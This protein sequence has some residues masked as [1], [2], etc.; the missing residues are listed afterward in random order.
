MSICDLTRRTLER[1]QMSE[2]K[3]L[4]E[5]RSVSKRYGKTQ[6]LDGISV[7][8]MRGRVY[9]LVGE[10]G[11]GKSTLVKI[12]C[13]A[14]T[15]D[16]GELL[17]AGEISELSSPQI[18]R[19]LGIS[20]V[21]QELS[22][23]PDL[24]LA[25]NI[26]LQSRASWTGNA[27]KRA[28][29]AKETAARWGLS[30][31]LVDGRVGS[32]SLRDQQLAEILC[33]LNRPHDVLIL[34]EPTS[35]L[36]PQ[37]VNWLLSV[38]KKVVE[39]GGTVL[40]ITHM[41]EE[42]ERFCDEIYVQRNGAIVGHLQKIDYRRNEVIELMIGRS[43]ETAFPVRSANPEGDEFLLEAHDIS[44]RGLLREVSLGI[45]RGEI[46]GVAGLDGQGQQDLF[47][48]LSGE[49]RIIT[50]SILLQGKKMKLTSPG[51]ALRP[52]NKSGG[53]ALVPAERKTHGAI[54]EMSIR[55]NV[56]LPV[57]RKFARF[58]GRSDKAE[59]LAVQDLLASVDVDT[60]KSQ[61][62]VGS[63]SGGNQQKV[64]FAR[65]LASDSEVLLLF[66]PTR[67]VDVGTKH[68]IYKLIGRYA[69]SGKAVLMYST[70]IPELVNVCH[71]VLVMYHG[72]IVSEKTGLGLSEASLM[73]A[74]IGVLK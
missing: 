36:L 34:D 8:L 57:L 65:A 9:G 42:I 58:Y 63:L 64:V 47:S 26:L 74:A 23:I 53:I 59:G 33:A 45:R 68:E 70:E 32:M 37:D 31:S 15:P 17:V 3:P 2:T 67:G 38:V 44:T 16:S 50:G 56:A 22:L 39:T 7:K 6:A 54:L 40:L 27:T 43:L 66:D 13:G 73:T 29:R 19:N 14:E 48:A 35:A 1:I 18:A 24:S 71:R 41:L 51:R 21:F 49:V 25:E 11:A 55:K 10:N 5:M 62:P 20:T 60:S 12:M 61:M 46:L 30:T 72:R 4:V 52:G 28:V 69:A